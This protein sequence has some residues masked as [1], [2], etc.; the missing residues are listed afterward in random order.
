MFLLKVWQGWTILISHLKIFLRYPSVGGGIGA[1]FPSGLLNPHNLFVWGLGALIIMLTVNVLYDVITK[2]T[3][4]PLATARVRNKID[5]L[6]KKG[7][8]I[9]Y[10]T[11]YRIGS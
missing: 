10:E 8:F 7:L 6:G 4:G 11:C 5:R 1:S 2:L 3:A 9:T